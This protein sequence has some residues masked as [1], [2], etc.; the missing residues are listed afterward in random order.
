M[1]LSAQQIR[2]QLA[3][4]NESGTEKGFWNSFFVTGKEIDYLP[5][6]LTGNEAILA[7]CTG[8]MSGTT[9]LAVC[10]DKRVIIL[11]RGMIFGVR[12]LQ[13]NLDRIQSI[14]HQTGLMFGSLQIW[15]GA[16]SIGLDMILKASAHRFVRVTREAMEIQKRAATAGFNRPAPPIDVASQ[17][18][19]LL[20]LKEKGALTEEEF[21][22]QKKKLLGE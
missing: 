5:Q 19:K 15:D 21:Q 10:T 7:A 16:A 4:L 14:D 2:A 20:A 22:T 6:L 8:F 3:K 18:E 9:W 12:V 17:I 11:N 1:P 13:T